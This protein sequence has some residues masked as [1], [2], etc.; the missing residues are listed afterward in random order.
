MALTFADALRLAAKDPRFAADLVQNPENYKQTFTLSDQQV[1][2]FK[3]ATLNDV[4]THGTGA[5]SPAIYFG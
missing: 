3:S 1:Q 5:A 2:G 4:L